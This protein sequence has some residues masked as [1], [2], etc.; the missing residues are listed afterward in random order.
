MSYTLELYSSVLTGQQAIGDLTAIAQDWERSIRLQGGPWLGSFEIVDEP[1]S[2]LQD[3]YYTL[4]GAHL[5]EKAGGTP[6]WVGFLGEP[7]LDDTPGAERLA[8][9]AFGYMNTAAWRFVT[10]GDGSMANASAWITEIL[11]TDCEFLTPGRI[12]TN[13]LQVKKEVSIEQR[14]WDELLK[15][16]E[17]GDGSGNIWRIYSDIDRLVHYEPLDPTPIYRVHGG[18][19]RRASLLDMVNY[20]RA[21]YIDLDNEVHELTPA[22]NPESIAEYGRKEELLNINA[23]SQAAAE[24]LRDSFLAEHAYPWGRALASPEPRLTDANGGEVNPWSVQPGIFRDM[25]YPVGGG[26]TNTVF[27]QDGRDFI[28]EEVHVDRDGFIS[29]RTIDYDEAELI[30]LQVKYFNDLERERLAEEAEQERERKAQQKKKDTD[31]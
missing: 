5:V 3:I 18:V 2:V 15:I 28:V 17:L 14:A 30:E 24:A 16:T 1:L 9:T 25:K 12:Q 13:T 11:T 6:S 31:I 8:V 20:V 22:S 26:E 7:E 23:V 4:R 10:V 27:L 19:I 21:N 29:L